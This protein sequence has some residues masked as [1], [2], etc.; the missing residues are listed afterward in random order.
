MA[1]TAEIFADRTPKDYSQYPPYLEIDRMRREGLNETD[2]PAFCRAY[3]T[4]HAVE[5]FND[6][7]RF[8]PSGLTYCDLK[9]EWPDSIL[10]WANDLFSTIGQWDFTADAAQIK[11]P[12]LLVQ[13][14]QDQITPPKGASAWSEAMANQTRVVWLDD[15]GHVPLKEHPKRTMGLIVG[16]LNGDRE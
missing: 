16:F 14:R 12:V 10:T 2:P 6:P 1:P 11:A 13:G 8:D 15:C 5:L 9:N 4:A 7:S 3:Y